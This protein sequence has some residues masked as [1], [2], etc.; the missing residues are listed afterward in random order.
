VQIGYWKLYFRFFHGSIRSPRSV[1]FLELMRHQTPG[2]LQSEANE[3]S[4]SRDPIL[5]GLTDFRVKNDYKQYGTP[6]RASICGLEIDQ[7][8]RCNHFTLKDMNI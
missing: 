5:E 8:R 4:L 6:H 7:D 3:P 2:G 1:E